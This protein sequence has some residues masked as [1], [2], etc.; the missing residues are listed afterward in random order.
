MSSVRF[1]AI[2]SGLLARKGEAQPWSQA[3]K[4][5]AKAE[6]W[7]QPAKA[8]VESVA[9]IPWR[10]YSPP[11]IEPEKEK[12]CSIRM[13]AHDYER[14]GIL[15]VKKDTTRQQ[16][17]KEALAEFLAAKAQDYGCACLHTPGGVCNQDCSSEA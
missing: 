6:A 7:S 12:T 5:A 4:E 13:S 16:L 1:A 17:L 15:A 9:S 2:T 11:V 14:L 10:P 8:E 3:A